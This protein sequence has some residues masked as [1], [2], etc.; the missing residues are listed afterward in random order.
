MLLDQFTVV[1]EDEEGDIALQYGAVM[2]ILDN[3]CHLVDHSEEQCHEAD[4]RDIED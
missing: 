2:F 4:A 3:H 1:N